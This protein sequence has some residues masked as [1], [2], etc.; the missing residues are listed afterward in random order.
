MDSDQCPKDDD[1]RPIQK[2][3]GNI[4]I[5][6]NGDA[7]I[8][9]SQPSENQFYHLDEHDQQNSD[10]HTGQDKVLFTEEGSS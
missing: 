8:L 5:I 4:T 7:F 1:K 3:V 6:D 10:R 9:P 2:V